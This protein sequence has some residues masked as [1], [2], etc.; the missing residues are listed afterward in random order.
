V[1]AERARK[2]KKD[3]DKSEACKGDM[4]KMQDSKEVELISAGVRHAADGKQRVAH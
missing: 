2:V 3:G 1:M 4:A